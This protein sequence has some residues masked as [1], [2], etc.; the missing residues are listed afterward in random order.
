MAAGAMSLRRVPAPPDPDPWLTLQEG[1]DEARVSYGTIARAA[2]VGRL[3]TV[4]VNAAHSR[5][6]RR[7]WLTAWLEGDDGDPRF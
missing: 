1:A 7:S 3:R 5:R 2:R 6:L 4:K